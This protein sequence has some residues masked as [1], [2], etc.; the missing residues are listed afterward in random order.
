MINFF[1]KDI[2]L[3][4]KPQPT[5]S[6]VNRIWKRSIKNSP[7][8]PELAAPLV[9]DEKEA[10][11]GGGS[12]SI[13]GS[14]HQQKCSANCYQKS[15]VGLSA[16]PTKAI[17]YASR[18]ATRHVRGDLVPAFTLAEVLITLGIIG[19]VAA[20]TLPT[21][22][23]NYKEKQTV[24]ALKTAYSI[25]SQAFTRAVEDNG[26]P[27]YWGFN[28]IEA[29]YDDNNNATF[30]NENNRNSSKILFDIFKKYLQVGQKCEPDN[31]KGCM[32]I[33]ETEGVYSGILANGMSF[34]F[35]P[36][37]SSCQ[38]V[39]GTSKALK[40]VCA[41]I[42]I[43]INGPQKG[44]NVGGKDTFRFYITKYGIIPK[45]TAN[46]IKFSF[47]N[48]CYYNDQSFG[49]ACT[50]WVLYNEN[51]DYLHCNDLSWDGKHKC[52]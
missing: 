5:K 12:Q 29:S 35:I 39:N 15:K 46:D 34:N 10:Y 36:R 30:D 52:K 27:E 33:G 3:G 19:V 45:G 43:D 18:T 49:E 2:L 51:M 47:K 26:S 24:T 4:L 44:E 23:Q 6:S 16:Q 32:K 20:M 38:E 17:S 7:C 28:T 14:S 11:K 25:F 22:I 48:R 50:A 13:S 21:L 31:K 1:K 37:N 9:A 41:D 40:H 8:H 42:T